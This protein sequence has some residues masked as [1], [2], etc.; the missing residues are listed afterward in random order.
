MDKKEKIKEIMEQARIGMFVTQS[1][2]QLYSRPISISKVEEDG[3]I[4]FFTDIGSEKVTEILQNDQVN[5][6]FSNIGK[7]EYVSVSGTAKV[8]ID[9]DKVDELWN[10]MV[11][12][13]FPEGKE[14]EDLTLIEVQP[15][16]VEYWDDSSSK[17]MLMYNMAKALATGK[18][19][20]DVADAEND[21]VRY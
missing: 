6:S 16:T 20:E 17:V 4:Y 1:N 15:E 8:I 18:S 21:V 12:V 5:F 9:Q 10:F 7:N 11:K 14:S 19:Y 13:W 3:R 2:N